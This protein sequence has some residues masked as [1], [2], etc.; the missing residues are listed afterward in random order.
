M[1]VDLFWNMEQFCLN[2]LLMPTVTYI[3]K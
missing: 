3:W 1:T 2:S